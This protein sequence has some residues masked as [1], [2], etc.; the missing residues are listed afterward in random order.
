MPRTR[1]LSI[2]KFFG[3]P[4][5]F[6]PSWLLIA[7][8]L[9]FYY[10]PI[11]EDAVPG[12]SS[13]S[14]YLVAFTYAVLFAICVLAHECG[15]T[16]VSLMLRMPVKRIVI[17]LL[18]GVSEIEREPERPRDEFLVAAAGPL[19]SVA[20]TG[21]ALL[22]YE[23][24]DPHTMVGV[25]VLLL[26]W[27]NLIVV[28]FNL[29]PGL[30]LD[31][32]RL[33]RAVVW[34]V[35]KSR[36]TGTRAGAWTGRVVAIGVLVLSL[37]VNRGP[38]GLVSGLVCVMLA[39]YLWFG[40]GQS[41]KIAEIMER[42]PRVD[43]ETLLRPGLLVPPDLSVA[44]AL[45]RMWQGSARGLVLVDAGDRPSAI[46]DEMQVN[47]V[48]MDRRPWVPLSTV[49]RPLEAGLVLHRGLI[50]EDL[51]AAIRAT[52]ASEY[53]VVDDDGTPA[54]ILATADLA[55]ALGAAR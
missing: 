29:L 9:T 1:L 30:P 8:L 38:S 16:A 19:V 54:G 24:L 52:P 13:S 11:V 53:L 32:G 5:Y 51:L 27:S 37:L 7:G 10:G 21:G 14:A 35:S 2:G 17:F 26:F 22:V 6:A 25:L 47:A 23:S 12:V 50:G 34:T 45:R 42:L 36:L 40:A 39:G 49:A 3:V 46:V 44:E 33:L 20:I 15:H 43:L 4:V 48:P 55:A 41:L 31:G 28:V 18:G